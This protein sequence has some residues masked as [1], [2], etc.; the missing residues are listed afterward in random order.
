MLDLLYSRAHTWLPGSS[1][2]TKALLCTTRVWECVCVSDHLGP[3]PAC[4]C[5]TSHLLVY[6]FLPCCWA[7]HL[8]ALHR[9]RPGQLGVA[10][11][12]HEAWTLLDSIRGQARK[13]HG[14]VWHS[15][16]GSCTHCTHLQLGRS[17]WWHSAVGSRCCGPNGSSKQAA[18]CLQCTKAAQH[19]N[20]AETST[21]GSLHAS[22][23][24]FIHF[25]R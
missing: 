2:G 13:H 22:S 23:L 6:L 19:P 9:C 4:L 3:F 8:I 17:C 15:G 20:G 7:P 21:W 18:T 14:C 5:L 24:H 16:A 11:I 25:W 10:C 1:Q 12:M